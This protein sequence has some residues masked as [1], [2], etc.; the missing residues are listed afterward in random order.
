MQNVFKDYYA[1]LGVMPEADDQVIKYVYRSLAR[2]YHPDVNPGDTDAEERFKDISEAYEVLG[3]P[4]RRKRFDM[5]REQYQQQFHPEN[6]L[7]YDYNWENVQ[8]KAD[9]FGRSLFFN[10]VD[11]VFGLEERPI[12]HQLE[13]QPGDDLELTVDVTLEEA[14]QGVERTLQ[15]GDRYIKIFVPP[16]V[17]TGTELLFKRD[18]Y[19]GFM[20]LPSGDLYIIVNVMPH[21]QFERE[22][23]DLITEVPVDIY[24]ALIGGQVSVPS[25]EGEI[26]L[27]IPARTQA[28]AIFCLHGKG[29]PRLNK[30]DERGDLY[31]QVRLVFPEPLS[32]MELGVLRK[33]A[34]KRQAKV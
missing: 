13:P 27:D 30:T 20:G 9:M 16:G 14:L 17:R 26:L 2:Q 3:N 24:T 15:L 31:V 29:M 18:G 32:D 10:F 28:D 21:I 12:Y 8:N 7:S 33:L 34:Q 4:E 25:M 6:G 23:D 22:G 1:V 5:L 11:M 19:P